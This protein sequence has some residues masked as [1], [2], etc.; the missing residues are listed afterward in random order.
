M[1]V[2]VCVGEYAKTPYQIPGVG[3][4]VF[5]MEELCFCMKENAFLLD[6]SLLNDELLNWIERECGLRELAKE[7]HPLV[8]K[9]GS[10]STFVM[11]ILRYVGFYDDES[12]RETESILKQGAGLSSIERRKIQIDVLVKKKKYKLALAEY[13]QLLRKWQEQEEQG[14]ILSGTEGAAA[15][16]FLAKIWHNKG[17]AF[18][19]LMLYNRAAECFKRACE[20]GEEEACYVA[21][22]AAERMLLTEKEYV[23]FVA[24]HG[25]LYR[26]TLELEKKLEQLTGEWEMQPDYLRLYNRRELR[27]GGEKQHYYEDSERLTQALKDSYRREV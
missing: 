22:L 14:G 25:E 5:C 2:S 19:G 3:M 9:R 10:L 1:R 6:L 15:K 18:T 20:L 11:T 12:L 16:D 27:S 8:H 13:D 4:R 17:V 23:A 21:Y 26:Y 7:L 24:E